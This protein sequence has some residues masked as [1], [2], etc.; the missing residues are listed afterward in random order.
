M[1]NKLIHA[2]RNKGKYDAKRRVDRRSYEHIKLLLINGAD[3]NSADIWGRTALMI[4]ASKN[5]ANIVKLL[6][7][8]GSD[9]NKKINEIGWTPLMES[10]FSCRIITRHTASPYAS[11]QSVDTASPYASTQSVD[12]E[13]LVN[14]DI[15]KLLVQS[16][17]D[18]NATN[19]CGMT[20]LMLACVQRTHSI[21][22][23]LIR[24]GAN[25]DIA[26]TNKYTAL[27]HA[28]LETN[29]AVVKDLLDSGA[30]IH[31]IDNNGKTALDISNIRKQLNIIRLIENEYKL[32]AAAMDGVT[33]V[34]DYYKLP[35][36]IDN[37]IKSFLKL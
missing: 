30:D 28:T 23:I 22:S 32:R 27:M 18:L 16:G 24:A 1:N 35:P 17:A 33:K 14:T 29:E 10:V 37:L 2:I 12:T 4:A 19:E 25:L 6:I 20:A 8:Y 3:A 31:A 15:V 9:I 5:S 26:D 34:C 36:G 7:D 11:T 21:V 13:V